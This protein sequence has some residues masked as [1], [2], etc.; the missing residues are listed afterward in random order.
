MVQWS[1]NASGQWDPVE[2]EGE[3]QK[4][5]RGG[6]LQWNA[7]LLSQYLIKLLSIVKYIFVPKV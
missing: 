7:A 4:E 5:G 3:T 1:E 6:H 2:D